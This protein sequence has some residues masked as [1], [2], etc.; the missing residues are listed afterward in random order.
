MRQGKF[1]TTS[2]SIG[3][4]NFEAQGG[5]LKYYASTK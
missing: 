2:A 1:P 3:D 4:G 5:D